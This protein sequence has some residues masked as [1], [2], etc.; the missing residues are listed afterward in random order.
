MYYQVKDIQLKRTKKDDLF[1]EISILCYPE[2]RTEEARRVYA[3]SSISLLSCKDENSIFNNRNVIFSYHDYSKIELIEK[4]DEME[5]ILAKME[6]DGEDYSDEYYELQLKLEEYMDMVDE[7]G[8]NTRLNSEVVNKE[9]KNI[10]KELI[11]IS[12]WYEKRIK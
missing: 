2:E 12:R 3:S 1:M 10:I 8:G 6:D 11:Q 4:I 7:E 9:V 5:L